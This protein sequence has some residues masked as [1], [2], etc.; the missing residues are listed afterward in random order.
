MPAPKAIE[1]L[2]ERFKNNY[3]DYKKPT[4]LEAELRNEFINPFFEALGWDVSN[5]LGRAEFCK[6]V[7]VENRIAV[8]GKKKAPDY[9]FRCFQPK[10]FVEAKKPSVNI[11][12]DRDSAFQI[13]RY[14]YSRKLPLS[15]L[16]NFEYFA[17]YE[18]SKKHPKQTD[19]AH[20]A[21]KLIIRY[22]DYVN[23]WSQ[24]WEIFSNERVQKGAFDRYAK[25]I[26]VKGTAQ[27]DSD[28]LRSIET[29]RELLA[30]NLV[31]KNPSIESDNLNY[32]VQMII[33]RL[34]FLRMC[35]DKGIY[36]QT[37]L[38][39]ISKGK[40]I[41]DSLKQL[42]QWT[43]DRFNSGMFHFQKEKGRSSVPDEVTPNL[44]ISDSVLEKLI[45][46]MYPPDSPY[47]FS[48]IPVEILGQAY[49]QFL[50]KVINRTTARQISV[51][52]KPEVRS[53]NGVYYTPQYIVDYI[54]RTT[55]NHLLEGK[56]PSTNKL[57]IIDPACG[58]GSFLVRAYQFL[59]DWYLDCYLQDVDKWLT[60]RIYRDQQ[61]NLKLTVSEKKR[62]LLNHIYGV[63]IDYQAV[64]VTKM[65]LLLK[66]LE[67]ESEDTFNKQRQ[68]E[69][70]QKRALPD[71][72]DNI[73]CG[74][75]LVAFD[76]D[77]DNEDVLRQVN[78]FDWKEEF[79]SIFQGNNPG[80]DVVI[81][82][83]PYLRIQGLQQF[84]KSQV[85][86]FKNETRY[87]SATGRF[88]YYELF[89]ERGVKLLAKRGMLGFICPNK[90][91]HSDAGKGLRRFLINNGVLHSLL[92][93]G[94]YKV[95]NQVST[96][97]GILLLQW[98]KRETFDYFEFDRDISTI[99][100]PECLRNPDLL[101]FN[102]YPIE[103][104]S[105]KPWLLV[106]KRDQIV[107]N[108]IQRQSKTLQ[109][110]CEQ[111]TVGIQSAID[112]LCVLEDRGTIDRYTK[113][114]FSKRL[115]NEIAI[116]GS[117]LKPFLRG[118]DVHRYCETD[119]RYFCLYP[120]KLK[121]GETVDIEEEDFK[122]SYPLAYAYLKP[123]KDELIE[124]KIMLKGNPKYWYGCHRCKDINVFE[125]PSIVT[126]EISL[127]CN[128]SIRPAGIYHNTKVYSFV[129]ASE[130]PENIHYWL[131]LLNSKLMW[132]FISKTGYVLNNG[133][134]V[135][136]TNYVNPFPARTINFNETT[137]KAHHDT[138]VKQVE[139]L[140]RLKKQK[141]QTK[142]Q[143]EET[144]VQ[145]QIH[146][147]EKKINETVY[148][149]YGLTADEQKVVEESAIGIYKD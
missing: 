78:R 24:I 115:G 64:E 142:N 136:K 46:D 84:H 76:F 43:D 33:D 37:P 88:D 138:I 77:S 102:S 16:T 30:K 51:E 48:V 107:L 31:W 87:E 44:N 59:M 28:F 106:N 67:N 57:R 47:E 29:W 22:E 60:K 42:F 139:E 52:Y 148:N 38:L 105:D 123:Y 17:V 128:M 133:F 143:T 109:E 132:W 117:I 90:F 89:I 86:Y 145:R 110:I 63:D 116:E 96:Y 91:V 26:T 137:E 98:T 70:F 124:R 108:K 72:S 127:G 56:T 83:P 93:F 92:N 112:D 74:N 54:V 103:A 10:F 45:H 131:G 73:K 129:F 5:K 75:S 49:E 3:D 118:D 81:G 50:G 8:Q 144:Y 99:E 122:T 20:K 13:R 11:A 19:E 113:Q 120:H 125:M 149:L 61:D 140:L 100:V 141:I 66:V 147:T 35:E 68:L 119:Y 1:E 101:N 130:M 18:Q 23:E 36:T 69:L 104:L 6:E 58:S 80:F 34:V 41:Y 55:L 134:Y 25:E 79:K 27:V 40:N 146:A 53:A 71:L 7:V 94:D 21:R 65:S 14:M 62:I 32:S 85:E 114:V 111:I 97:T 12:T 126:P 15:I 135:F 82:N 4:Y 2:V 9:C 121:N 95:W 39:E